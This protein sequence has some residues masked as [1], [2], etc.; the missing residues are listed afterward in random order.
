MST[1][2]SFVASL[3]WFV[4]QVEAPALRVVYH[5]SQLAIPPQ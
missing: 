5:C 2:I 4:P 3:A 1:V